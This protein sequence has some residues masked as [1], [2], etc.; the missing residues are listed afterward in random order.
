MK[1][2]IVS[3]GPNPRIAVKLQTHRFRTFGENRAQRKMKNKEI[4]PSKPYTHRRCCTTLRGRGRRQQ[5]CGQLLTVHSRFHSLGLSV[6][7]FLSDSN[8]F[9]VLFITVK[10]TEMKK[11]I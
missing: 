11:L 6:F 10:Q 5:L 7:S 2:S 3:F 1:L 9:G 8:V 4:T